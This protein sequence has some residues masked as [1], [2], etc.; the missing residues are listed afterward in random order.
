MQTLVT[1]FTVWI[2]NIG[3][4]HR[5]L[6]TGNFPAIALDVPVTEINGSIRKG[7]LAML[8]HVYMGLRPCLHG[9]ERHSL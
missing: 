7:L 9:S 3:P 6:L 5:T 1:D 8:T 2:C 4:K